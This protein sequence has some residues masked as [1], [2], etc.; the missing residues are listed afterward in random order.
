M[1]CRTSTHDPYYIYHIVS[2]LPRG[3]GPLLVV[4]HVGSGV[5]HVAI[6]FQF[7]RKHGAAPI[8]SFP[9]TLKPVA[10]HHL[11]RFQCRT[12]LLSCEFSFWLWLIYT[13][14]IFDP[15]VLFISLFLCLLA[16]VSRWA[17]CACQ[18]IRLNLTSEQTWTSW[19]YLN[20]KLVGHHGHVVNIS[21]LST[22]R[23]DRLCAAR[24]MS[25]GHSRGAA[26][27]WLRRTRWRYQVAWTTR[28]TEVG[29]KW[30]NDGSTRVNTD[31]HGSTRTSL[32]FYAQKNQLEPRPRWKVAQL[33]TPKPNQIVFVLQSS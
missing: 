18:P 6:R 14:I 12:A 29:V 15:M 24:K 2:R 23:L 26:S 11:S 5:Y 1:H 16:H 10:F 22:K 33:D 7:L 31:Q 25:L 30:R 28:A 8:W 13:Y 21:T 27:A 4:F 32:A 3:H 17:T 20:F 9:D 19:R